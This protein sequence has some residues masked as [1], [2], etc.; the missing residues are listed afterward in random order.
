MNEITSF[1]YYLPYAVLQNI[2][3][4]KLEVVLIFILIISMIIYISSVKRNYL[5]ALLVSIL[6]LSTSISIRTI[7]TS[8]Q[9]L[10]TDFTIKNA[11]AFTYINGHQALVFTNDTTQAFDKKFNYHIQ[12]L[13]IKH[14]ATWEIKR[15]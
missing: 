3:I 4:T 5:F 14:Q 11:K 13:L 6:L 10:I 12:P 8:Q 1:I 9:T 7:A 2:Y 15:Y